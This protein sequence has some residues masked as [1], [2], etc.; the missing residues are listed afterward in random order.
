MTISARLGLVVLL[1][2][3]LLEATAAAQI[4][5]LPSREPAAPELSVSVVSAPSGA[6]R[7]ATSL[8]V[9]I[10]MPSGTYIDR[11]NIRAEVLEPAGWE[12]G[13][14]RTPPGRIKQVAGEDFEV[15]TEPFEAAFPLTIPAG[16]APGS[17]PLRI[18]LW[19]VTCTGDRCIPVDKE[20]LS[21]VTIM[22]AGQAGAPTLE[23]AR[24]GDAAA[25]GGS[26][27]ERVAGRLTAS[28]DGGSIL[29]ALPLA[30]FGGLLLALT[31]CVLPIVPIV[32]SVLVGGGEKPRGRRVVN[33]VVYTIGLALVYAVLGLVA[34]L[35]GGLVGAL[36][37]HVAVLIAFTAMFG[38]LALSMFDVYEL[39]MPAAL[40]ARLQYQGKGDLAGAFVMGLV[41]GL[42][43]SPCIGP[44]IA[45]VLAWI[46]KTQNPTFGFVVLF[47]MGCGLGLPFVAAGAVGGAMLRP[48]TWMNKVK[49]L[50][51]AMLLIGSAYFADLAGGWRGL[52][53]AAGVWGAVLVVGYLGWAKSEPGGLR[54]IRL[55][56]LWQT[57]VWGLVLCLVFGA[58]VRGLPARDVGGGEAGHIA[59]RDDLDTAL[60]EAAAQK[61]P[62]IIYFTADW[63]IPCREMKGT[64]FADA[65]VIRESERFIPIMVDLTNRGDARLKKLTRDYGIVGPPVLIFT[66]AQ[67]VLAPRGPDRITGKVDAEGFL[68]KLRSIH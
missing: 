18:R 43:A 29:P 5:G 10:G 15:L 44:V 45:G 48:G 25:A 49:K 35:T 2:L 47:T 31:P 34:G 24:T 57:G 28:L 21:S 4:P 55:G 42:I 51:G 1:I 36:L 11:K 61:R 26:F 54:R 66:D 20:V 60:A 41:S 68:A 17:A 6:P 40:Q 3:T 38:L 14:P 9:G 33:S 52:L 65:S 59:W 63:C 53:I 46:A 8:V 58:A 23:K 27:S 56:G 16:V 62:A 19:C 7:A 30:L 39:A 37:Q 64:T 32:V 67:G 13:A 22:A 50:L 12:I